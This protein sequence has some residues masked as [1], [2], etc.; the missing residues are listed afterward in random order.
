V[1]DLKLMDYFRLYFTKVQLGTP[2]VE[3]YVQIDT[4]SDVL[5]VSCSSCSGCPQTSGLQ[6]N[7]VF[8]IDWFSIM[9]SN[10]DQYNGLWIFVAD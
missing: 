1:F 8:S 3:F 10:S 2:P 9:F 6:V 7:S 4:G 5:W